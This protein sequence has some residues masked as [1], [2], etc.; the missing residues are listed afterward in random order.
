MER[1]IS[2]L[3]IDNDPVI[4]SGLKQ[5][6]MGRGNNLLH[7]N[8]IEEAIPI[9]K[10]KEIGIFLL[11]IED[12][13][14]GI[15]SVQI[16]KENK[17]LQNSYIIVV[18]KEDDTG[19]KLVKGMHMGA[20]DYITY[21]FNPNLIKSKIEVFKSLFYKDQRIGQL[22]TNIFPSSVLEELQSNGKFSPKKIDNGIILFTDFVDFSL[23]SKSLKP[24]HLIQTL[25]KYFIKFDEIILKYNLEKIKTIG[26]AYMAM[27]GVTENNPLPA[28]RACLA[29]IELRNYMITEQETAIAMKKD[30]WE[31]RIGLHM[32]PLV[33]GI[34]GTAK[35]SYDVW[36]DTVNIASRTESSSKNN[37]IS[38]T[39]TIHAVIS[40]FFI[41]TPRGKIDIKKRGGSIEMFYLEQ[42]ENV[43]SM[44]NEGNFP[45]AQLRVKC[46]LSPMDFEQMK[47]QIVNK[48]KS[49]LPD[50]LYYHDVPHSLNV[51]KAV[52]RYAKL[53]G[54]AKEDIL[55][56]RT[57]A[58]I[59]DSGFMAKYDSNEDFAIEFA[60][61]FL[62]QFGYSNQQVDIISNMINATKHDIEPANLLEE[63]IID[64]DYD[65][66]G[67][68][69]Y[70]IIVKKLRK[71]MKEFGQ[72]FTDIEW[73]NYQYNFLTT[74][75]RYYTETAQNIR[76]IG[77]QSR[78]KKIKQQIEDI[79]NESVH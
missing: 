36:G 72:E 7:A 11:N 1:F 51:E 12:V 25:E 6:L 60:Q 59:H 10:K 43:F 35:Y 16:L 41:T 17:I 38:I 44:Y 21:P 24:I 47:I 46:G 52:I 28:V 29:A 3:I 8:T 40:D 69:D 20:V 50:H 66:L 48:L 23:K 5:I 54:I 14:E 65:Y 34:I 33:T 37:S 22:L 64:A 30:F 57:A 78:I 63:I 4:Q 55:L 2:I 56:L 26:D 67:R 53:E 32:G 9:I 58:L 79:E 45:N 76:E 39:D 75:H 42:I 73:L 49:L 70:P 19:S 18:A 13:E 77:K 71:E 27:A 62:P 15:N 31:V 61:S 68:P 74:K